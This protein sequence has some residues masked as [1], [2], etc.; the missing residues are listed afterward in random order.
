LA[1]ESSANRGLHPLHPLPPQPDGVAWPA[2]GGDRPGSDGWPTGPLD[3]RVDRAAFEQLIARAFDDKGPLARTYALV[4]IHRGTLVF[5]R[6]A[7][8]LD[9][10]GKPGE[11]VEPGTRLLSWSM[12]KS[13]LHAAV[14]LLVG[15][16]R[17]DPAAPATVPEWADPGDPRHAI[18]VTDLLAMR[19]GLEFNEDYV[20]GDTSDVIEM[21]FGQSAADM[22]HF[23]ADRPL[24][25]AP[26][27]RFNYSSGTSNIIAG[28]LARTVGPGDAT[29]AFLRDRL[30]APIGMASARPTFDDQGTWI[31]SSYVYATA[32]DFARFGLFY[33]RDGTWDGERLLPAGWV[34]DA[35]WT[36]SIDPTDGFPYGL[37]WWVV[38]D[39]RS[40]FRAAGHDGQSI[41]CCPVHDL[42]VVR[43]GKTPD[44]HTD[45]LVAW[46]AEMVEL[47]DAASDAPVAGGQP[48]S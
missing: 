29:G 2:V 13:I 17:L 28:I 25:A 21:L 44:E 18:T 26:G 48:P 42:V 8:E 11:P 12:A 20:D 16:G 1:A 23:A 10:W 30:F 19:D 40:T 22:A 5:E 41:T 37:H 38:D 15:D 36:R 46:R 6:Y 45:D 7:G 39:G 34:D 14:G 32:R 24:A 3:D 43:L 4:V 33:L 9:G 47:F 31:A 35:R 27:E